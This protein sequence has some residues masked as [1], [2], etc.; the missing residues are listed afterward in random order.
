M[1]KNNYYIIYIHIICLYVKFS[2]MFE[3]Q[4]YNNIFRIFQH[5]WVK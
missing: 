1:L 4:K 2:F 3:W 5:F